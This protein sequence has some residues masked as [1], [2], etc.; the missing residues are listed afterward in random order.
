MDADLVVRG[1]RIYTADPEKP[2]AEALAVRDGRIVRIGNEGDVRSLVGPRT[3]VLDA[4]GRLVLP[5]FIDAHVHL[6]WGYELGTWIDLT[7]RPSLREVQR[8]IAR[9]AELNPDEAVILGHGFDYAA[10]R[11]GGLPSKEDLDVAA[12]DRPVIITAWDGHT[13][14][15]NTR[16]TMM[17]SEAVA[18]TGPDIGEMVRDPRTREPTGVFKRS[19]DVMAL[20]PEI[21]AR[22]S[23]EGLRES[24][25]MAARVGITTAFDVQVN[26][27]DVHAYADLWKAGEL[28]ARIRAA[29]Y[30]PEATPRELYPMYEQA[31]NAHADDWFRVEAVKLY[32]DGVQETGTAALLEPY[33]DRPQSRGETVYDVPRFKDIVSE[34]DRLGFQICTHACGDRGVRIALDAYEEAAR[35]NGTSGR[36]HRV[37]HCENVAPED[38]PRFARLGV[39]PCMMPR[40]SAPE[41][42]GR[43]RE[44]LG[45][46]RERAGFAWR[47]MID[48][49]AALAFSSDWP[50]SDVNPLVGIKEAVARRTTEGSPSPHRVSLTEAIDGYTRRAAYACH[51]ETTRGSLEVGKYADLV[52]LSEDLFGMPAERIPEAHVVRTVVGGRTVFS[53]APVGPP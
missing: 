23:L 16:F 28:T 50:V 34:F 49:G 40:H 26:L 2:R 24:L 4:E 19:F 7:D 11:A 43:W 37:E 25:A 21:Q 9:H 52:V 38:A 42:L 5:G 30:H 27:T 33:A 45:P 48:T 13:G 51:A 22:R 44:A 29:I 46:D 8:R 12:S 36:R 20:L 39:V 14:L 18:K 35:R 32:I 15:G 17:A 53:E 6:I 47:E 10:L 3:E 31:R 1:A 41:L